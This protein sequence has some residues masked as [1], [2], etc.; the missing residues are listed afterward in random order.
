MGDH[1]LRRRR[2]VVADVVDGARPGPVD[3]GAQ[4]GGDVVHVDAAEHLA[5]LDDAPRRP[6]ADLGE[7]SP[8]R[9][10]DAREPKDVERQAGD[11]APLRL[12]R[13]ARRAPPRR[14]G[15]RGVLVHPFPAMVA[16][17]ARGREVARPVEPRRRFGDGPAPGA[18]HR[19]D[20][21]AGAGA[22]AGAAALAGAAAPVGCDRGQQMG[23]A[24]D[25][26]GEVVAGEEACLDPLR[27]Q[28][29]GLLR[30]ARRADHPPTGQQRHQRACRVAVAEGEERR[31]RAVA[32]PP[33]RRIGLPVHRK[34][35]PRSVEPTR[36]AGRRSG[37]PSARLPAPS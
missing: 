29:L 34:P 15:E 26:G 1:L 30:R 25:V 8:A 6:R 2:I 23:R 21:L 31:R 37:A 13:D 9:P 22:P 35:P 10:V 11:R 32:R 33:A 18:Q 24:G 4:H 12:G 17:N 19:V 7:G 20:G 27:G 5:R 14:G 16:I 3:R 36:A 28:R